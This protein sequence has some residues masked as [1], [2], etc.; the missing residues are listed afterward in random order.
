MALRG[1]TSTRHGL[2]N[3]QKHPNPPRKVMLRFYSSAKYPVSHNVFNILYGTLRYIIRCISNKMDYT[4]A[5]P[6]RNQISE[7]VFRKRPAEA[8]PRISSLS[9]LGSK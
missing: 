6:N 4:G 1:G 8:Q 2:Q 7:T 9:N 5:G 3:F